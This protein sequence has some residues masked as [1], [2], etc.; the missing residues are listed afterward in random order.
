MERIPQ[1]INDVET[2]YC[3]ISKVKFAE[4]ARIMGGV[5]IPANMANACWKPRRR[6]RK[7]GIRS[8]RPKKGAALRSFFIKGRFGLKRNA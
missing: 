5:M 2:R 3:C 7:T 8:W 6:A 1:T 4:F